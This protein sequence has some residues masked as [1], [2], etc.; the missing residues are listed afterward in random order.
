MET[1]VHM[2]YDPRT[3]ADTKVPLHPAAER[4]Y[5]EHGFLH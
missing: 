5:R 2:A 4:Y 1:A 3:V